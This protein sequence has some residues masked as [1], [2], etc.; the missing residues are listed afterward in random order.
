MAFTN[1]AVAAI[2]GAAL[3]RHLLTLYEYFEPSH[4]AAQSEWRIVHPKPLYGYPSALSH[5]SS[6]LKEII[7]RVSPP[8]GWG[9]H[10]NVLSVPEQE[11]V[12]LVCPRHSESAL[13]RALPEQFAAKPRFLHDG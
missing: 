2:Q 8:Q 7:R 9:K 13:L 1:K 10:L 3:W 11:V 5:G 12:G 6:W 4:N